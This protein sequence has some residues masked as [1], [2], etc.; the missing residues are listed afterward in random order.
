ME[1]DGDSP[2]GGGWAPADRPAYPEEPRTGYGA[3]PRETYPA[4]PEPAPYVPPQPYETDPYDSRRPRAPEPYEPRQAQEPGQPYPPESFES[5]G[6]FESG[7]EPEPTAG[8]GAPPGYGMPDAPPMAGPWDAPGDQRAADSASADAAPA[9]VPPD[10]LAAGV[11]ALVA[12]V[13]FGALLVGG[14]LDRPLGL[15]ACVLVQVAFVAAL[16]LGT[17]RPGPVV[18][19]AVGL[20]AGLVADAYAGFGPAVSLAPFGYVLAG[21]LLAGAAGQLAR[22]G[23]RTRV[24]D[25]LASTM[26]AVIGTVAVPS[27]VML[28]RHEHGVEALTTLLGAAAAGVVVARLIDMFWHTPRASAP[29]ARGVIGVVAG[30][31]LAAT[32]VGYAAGVAT[33]LPALQSA[34]AGLVMGLAAV[35]SDIG[36]SFGSSG[37][38]LSG[39]PV[40]RLP[41]RFVLGPAFAVTAAAPVGY[42]LGWLVLLPRA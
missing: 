37:T 16:V 24:T 19:A 35:L 34:V 40:H 17:R 8:Y 6:G 14:R 26:Y 28:T 20:G 18:V 23:D 38:E 30:G 9:P 4:A 39:E 42:V 11:N 21:G 41:A 7:Y 31:V 3:A 29:V 36:I 2:Y 32:A 33:G 25:S 22:G 12:L 5:R 27:A 10:R 15:A 1:Y 13:L